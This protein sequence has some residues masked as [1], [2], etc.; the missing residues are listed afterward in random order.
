MRQVPQVDKL[1]MPAPNPVRCARITVSLPGWVPR[2][3]AGG[4]G[5]ARPGRA[6][7]G[8]ALAARQ[9]PPL[10]LGT[11]P[12]RGAADRAGGAAAVAGPAA[13]DA[14]HPPPDHPARRWWWRPGPGRAV[15]PGRPGA[16]G[17]PG[18][19]R[20]TRD[21]QRHAEPG[22][23]QPRPAGR[24]RAAGPRPGRGGAAGCGAGRPRHG[25]A[26]RKRRATATIASGLRGG[27]AKPRRRWGG[28][29]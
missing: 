6:R 24:R 12:D 7:C 4:G 27:A 14:D 28:A 5:L 10:R 13:G 3:A 15:R 9:R 17:R 23:V 1:P 26:D 22:G 11:A 29:A 8:P 25:H 16:G 19:R 2:R 21:L 18:P 20:P